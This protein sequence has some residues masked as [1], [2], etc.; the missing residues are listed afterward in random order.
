M[1]FT[2][3]TSKSTFLDRLANNAVPKPAADDKEVSQGGPAI[4]DHE[5]RAQAL[6][7]G[8]FINATPK[9]SSGPRS[10]VP[11]FPTKTANTNRFP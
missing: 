3:P 11:T 5:A 4:T 6:K 10:A 8:P 7:T 9:F 1:S 2:P